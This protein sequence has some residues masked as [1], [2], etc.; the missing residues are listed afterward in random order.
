[1][2]ISGTAAVEVTGG[3]RYGISARG[4][5]GTPA[6][7]W[8]AGDAV[9]SLG[10]SIGD[11]YIELTSTETVHDHLGPTIAIYSRTGTAAWDDTAPVVA[12]GNLSSF[13]GYGVDTFGI[14][15]GND[16]TLDPETGFKGLTADATQGLRLFNTDIYLYEDGALGASFTTEEGILLLQ[17]VGHLSHQQRV[18]SWMR[19]IPAG[20]AVSTITSY[21]DAP[22][23]NYLR[24]SASRDAGG[25]VE[26]DMRGGTTQI[27]LGDEDAGGYL[28]LRSS[29]TIALRAPFTVVGPL[30]ETINGVSVLTVYEATSAVGTGA[31]LT[32][33]QAGSGD[34]VAQFLLTGGQRFVMGIDKTDNKFKITDSPDLATNTLLS[35]DPAFDRVGIGT[36]TAAPPSCIS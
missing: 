3:W 6:N 32:I 11:G 22:G 9:V 8:L 17:D 35:I 24:M 30:A 25:H 31:G 19:E 20:P 10:N 21:S 1:M 2:R 5:D 12:M 26:T 4:A 28:F 34:A 13:V 15:L 33:E 7:A 16:L 29:E 27:I 14:A 36:A 23:W 18:I